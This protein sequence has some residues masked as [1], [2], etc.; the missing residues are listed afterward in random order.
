VVLQKAVGRRLARL[1]V[2]DQHRHDMGVRRHQGQA[3]PGQSRLRARYLAL[4]R[5]PLG[6]GALEMAHGGG[7]RRGDSRRQSGRENEARSVAAHGIDDRGAGGDIA[8][9]HPK[10]LCQGAFDN[11]DAVH[12]PIALGDAAATRSVHADR[13]NL[14][15]IGERA[16]FL[17]QF[18]DALDGGDI[19]VHGIDALADDQL[20]PVGSCG[21][22]K[23]FKMRNVVVPKDL[24][25]AARLAHALDH[26]IVVEGV[27]EDEAVRDQAGDGGDAGLVRDIARGED[28]GRLLAVQVGELRLQRHD[29]MI[30]AGNVPRAAGARTHAL[31][32]LGQGG[33][34]GRVLPHAEIIVGAPDGDFAGSV[35]AV[36]QRRGKTAGNAFQ[37]GEDAVA[38][39]GLQRIEGGMEE[40]L[41]IHRLTAAEGQRLRMAT[42]TFMVLRLPTALISVNI[43]MP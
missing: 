2:P 4:L 11:V 35:R 6:R 32:C 42:S 43:G 31:G 20:R 34:R 33:D 16:V 1:G 10:S 5:L 7:R 24:L 26:G 41:V 25:L 12:D 19:A 9:H 3:G 27:G 39:L 28:E 18:A 23:L 30:V 40:T 36:P 8:A 21:G 13:M 29:R 37:I 17:G 14:V 38:P 15:E 22:E